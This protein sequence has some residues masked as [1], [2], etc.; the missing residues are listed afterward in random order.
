[1]I[2]VSRL[3]GQPAS[4]PKLKKMI[5]IYPLSEPKG[6]AKNTGNLGNPTGKRAT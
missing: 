3:C 2:I 1:L 6:D 5:K 4:D